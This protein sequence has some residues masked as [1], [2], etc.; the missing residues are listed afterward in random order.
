[1]LHFRDS[2]TIRGEPT[3]VTLALARAHGAG[4]ALRGSLVLKH[5][6]VQKEYPAVEA[7]L[8]KGLMLDTAF[9][10]ANLPDFGER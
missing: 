10:Q 4:L 9:P 8:D 7:P 3:F 2:L 5:A 1:M 6:G